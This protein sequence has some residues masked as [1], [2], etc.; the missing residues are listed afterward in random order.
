MDSRVIRG[1]IPCVIR[2]VYPTFAKIFVRSIVLKISI[3]KILIRLK[4][5]GEI[6]LSLKV[7]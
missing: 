6:G 5:V 1:V 3:E 4:T 2:C 7:Y